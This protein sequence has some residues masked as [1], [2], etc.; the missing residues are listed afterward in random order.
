MSKEPLSITHPEL[1]QQADGWD[2]TLVSAGSGKKLPWKC[3]KQHKWQA[4]V[5][6]RAKNGNGCPYC[7]GFRAIPGETD[8][9]TTHPEIAKQADGWDPTDV[10]F[11][12]SKLRDWKC[13]LG[14]KWVTSCNSRTSKE[15]TGCPICSNQRLL[16][17]FNDLTTKFPEIAKQADGW[18]PSEVSGGAKAKANWICNLGHKWSAT[19]S[20]RTSMNLGCPFCSN[21][22]I[23]KG[24]NDLE[25]QFPELAIQAV[26]WDPSKVSP[27]TAAKRRWK[28]A[29][30]HVWV[31]SVSLRTKRGLGCPYCSGQKLLEGFNDLKTKFPEIASEAYGWNPSK[32]YV[33]N[34][35]KREWMCDYGHRWF[36][37][38]Q[39]RTR[40]LT[41][42]PTC[43]GRVTESGFNDL[44]TRFPAIADE[45][46]GWDP[47]LISPGSLERKKWKCHKGHIW[48]SM[49]ATR[50][51]LNRGC[52]TCSKTGFDPNKP[53][54]LYL[55]QHE[56]WGMLQIGI[57]NVPQSRLQTHKK[58][59]WEVLDLRGPMD[60]HDT[61]RWE[62]DILSY[63]IMAN[64]EF[65]AGETQGKFTGFTESWMQDSHPIASIKM[66]MDEVDNFDA[67]KI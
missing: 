36:A 29:N 19:I 18:E 9:S 47:S 6:S 31:T 48:E 60:G 27:G 39:Q 57:S 38:P 53:G 3:A 25:S 56:L 43:M 4:V 14:H 7:S 23:L 49:V 21:Q 5:G 54:W 33:G 10:S 24:F 20:S 22:K 2:P 42:C 58:N 17:G 52:P 59:G 66:L 55:L 8:L 1:S 65:V 64:A 16:K 12:S 51:H 34:V 67:T 35:T 41:G 46:L 37:T 13:E 26:G 50:A 30:D 61:Y 45:A 15:I 63:L 40:S 44:S 62:Q 28:C 32:I 11:G